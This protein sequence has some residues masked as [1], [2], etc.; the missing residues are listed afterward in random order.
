MGEGCASRLALG[1]VSLL[2]FSCSSDDDDGATGGSR[3]GTEGGTAASAASSGSS[4]VAGRAGNSGNGSSSGSGSAGTA[5]ASQGGSSAG[6]PDAGGPQHFPI[7][8]SGGNEPP[9]D[10]GLPMSLEGSCKTS[11]DCEL[12]TGPLGIGDPCCAGCPLVSSKEICAQ[13]RAAMSMCRPSGGIGICP[14]VSCVAPVSPACS[15]EGKCVMG[16]GIEQ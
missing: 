15:A 3:S 13:I 8:G 12:C 11:A 7:S 10:S 1:L 16:S 9:A 4:G 2:L 5:G 6:T 14:Q